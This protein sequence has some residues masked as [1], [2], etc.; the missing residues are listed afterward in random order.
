[1][2]TGT[3]LS[4]SSIGRF[5]TLLTGRK[6]HIFFLA[7]KEHVTSPDGQVV[8]FNGRTNS[9][10]T[11]P[12]IGETVWYELESDALIVKRWCGSRDFAVSLGLK[13]PGKSKPGYI[14]GTQLITALVARLTG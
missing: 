2:E 5:G 11:A 4:Y 12:E 14:V 8:I 13:M 7:S 9:D 1:M 3:V 10:P 6:E